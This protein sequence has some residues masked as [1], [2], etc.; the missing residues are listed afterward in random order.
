MRQ[1]ALTGIESSYKKFLVLKAIKGMK[2]K[3]DFETKENRLRML[4]EPT[5]DKKKC[6]VK[7]KLKAQKIKVEQV[8]T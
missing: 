2:R 7:K 8:K 1:A 3:T 4:V 6:P 5:P